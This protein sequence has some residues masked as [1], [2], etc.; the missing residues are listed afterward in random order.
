MNKDQ[1]KGSARKVAGKV[2]KTAGKTVGSKKTE[3]KGLLRE[4]AG[5]FQKGYGDGREADRKRTSRARA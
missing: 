1:L 3:A 5:A 2:Q 4:M